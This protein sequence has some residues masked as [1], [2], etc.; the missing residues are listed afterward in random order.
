MKLANGRLVWHDG[1]RFKIMAL[2]GVRDYS[3][4]N[5]SD[6]KLGEIINAMDERFLISTN[7]TDYQYT[8]D[9]VGLMAYCLIANKWSLTAAKNEATI[10]K[11]YINDALKRVELKIKPRLEGL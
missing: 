9:A 4:R 3:G 6:P 1:T 11:R 5:F 7:G 2:K 8:T 10:I